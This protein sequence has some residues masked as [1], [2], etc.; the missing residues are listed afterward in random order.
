[1]IRAVGIGMDV[2]YSRLAGGERRAARLVSVKLR[3]GKGNQHRPVRQIEHPYLKRNLRVSS[4]ERTANLRE[5]IRHR[6]K[7]VETG[8][9]GIMIA[10]SGLGGGG[11]ENFSVD[12]HG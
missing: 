12:H 4:S 1:M 7:F 3:D 6:I 9:T 8:W 2:Y 10:R 5:R 11:T